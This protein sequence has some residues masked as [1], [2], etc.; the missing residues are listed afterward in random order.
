[1]T[2]TQLAKV[3]RRDAARII[4]DAQVGRVGGGD[5]LHLAIETALNEE[6]WRG[7]HAGQRAYEH[8]GGPR[9]SNT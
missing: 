7:F 1:M 2:P 8:E 4:E 9:P 3:P 5:R 6:W